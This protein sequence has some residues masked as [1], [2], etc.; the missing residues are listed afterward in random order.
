MP[1]SHAS[2]L[3][4]NFHK[5]E[6]LGEAARSL[7]VEL[8]LPPDEQ[9]ALAKG[10]RDGIEQADRCM[11]GISFQDFP[12]GSCGDAAPLLGRYLKDNGA[13]EVTYVLGER[14]HGDSRQSHAWLLVDGCIVDI[15]A[16]QFPDI[17]ERIVVRAASTW[18]ETFEV[19]EQHSGD[20][21]VYDA[22]TVANLDR[23]YAVILGAIRAP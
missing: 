2:S 3:A 7:Q 15:T 19:C 22:A 5:L 16:D 14:G 18:H 23:I 13:S 6:W 10:F 17:Q 11:L 12:L 4:K 8:M 20:Y 1:A 21:R 9:L